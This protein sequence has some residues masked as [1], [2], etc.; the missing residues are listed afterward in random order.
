MTLTDTSLKLDLRKF[1]TKYFTATITTYIRN[2]GGLRHHVWTRLIDRN[3]ER[4]DHEF[5]INVGSYCCYYSSIRRAAPP[6]PYN[7]RPNSLNCYKPTRT[8]VPGSM[9]FLKFHIILV[10]CTPYK[11]KRERKKKKR[12]KSWT[13]QVVRPQQHVQLSTGLVKCQ[14]RFFCF[15]IYS[16]KQQREW[17]GVKG[18]GKKRSDVRKR[19]CV[20]IEEL[21][22]SGKIISGYRSSVSA[23]AKTK[24]ACLALFCPCV[25]PS[26]TKTPMQHFETFSFWWHWNFSFLLTTWSVF[27]LRIEETNP[28]YGGWLPFIE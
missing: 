2:D 25:S 16:E 15:S 26:K 21:K 20:V 5:S 10:C 24:P 18:K 7:L 1:E 8:V 23:L 9:K 6:V 28:R 19:D 3:N 14:N 12:T 13:S 27:W 17:G 4:K 22:C 11:I